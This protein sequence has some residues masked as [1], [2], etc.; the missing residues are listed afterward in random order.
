VT[1]DDTIAPGT[2]HFRSAIV[3]RGF[4]LYEPVIRQLG[5]DGSR[6]GSFS[7]FAAKDEHSK[8]FA[9]RPTGG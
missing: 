7:Q 2:L 5:A 6:R 1:G 9:L 4:Q 3:V 8:S